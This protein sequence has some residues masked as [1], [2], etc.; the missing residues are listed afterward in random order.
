MLGIS[1]TLFR[2]TTNIRYRWN[3][4]TTK[5]KII[6]QKSD[7]KLK[8]YF[9][10]ILLLLISSSTGLSLPKRDQEADEYKEVRRLTF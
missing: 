5:E 6:N 7:I 3:N 10:S 8:M 4:L 9:L 2:L 1:C